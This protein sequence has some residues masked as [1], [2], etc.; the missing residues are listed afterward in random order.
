MLQYTF[1][2]NL[3]SWKGLCHSGY[4]LWT[5]VYLWLISCSR[6]V[7]RKAPVPKAPGPKVIPTELRNPTSVDSAPVSHGG[8]LD[9]K[10]T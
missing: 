1:T 2:P 3:L 7:T 5:D 9:P 4:I 10:K 8:F 6:V